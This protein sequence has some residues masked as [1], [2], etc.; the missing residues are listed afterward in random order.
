[1]KYA[2]IVNSIVENI[3][4]LLKEDL[5]SLG[6]VFGHTRKSCFYILF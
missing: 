1:M 2:K 3:I 4:V 5:L 6:E